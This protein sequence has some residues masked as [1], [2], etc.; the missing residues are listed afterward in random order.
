MTQAVSR[1]QPTEHLT[2]QQVEQFVTDGFVVVPGLIDPDRAQAGLKV[3]QDKVGIAPDD[4]ATWPEGK[5]IQEVNKTAQQ[6]FDR[7]ACISPD[8]QAVVRELGGSSVTCE[9]GIM[10]ILRFPEDG[11]K[12]FVPG[13]GHI[14]GTRQGNGLTVFPTH[15][16]LLVACYITRTVFCALRSRLSLAFLFRHRTYCCAFSWMAL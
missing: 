10:P 4:P 11:P 5:Q 12:E 8:I 9:G 13:G 3:L 2:Q 15:F 1:P 16:R 14:D 7:K 6:G